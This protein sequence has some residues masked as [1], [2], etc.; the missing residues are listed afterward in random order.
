MNKELTFAEAIIAVKNALDTLT[1]TGSGNARILANA[2]DDLMTIADAV[3]V[4]MATAAKGG[5][6]DDSEKELV[7]DH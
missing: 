1:V 2:C 4:Y 7:S 3:K 6:A 5:K